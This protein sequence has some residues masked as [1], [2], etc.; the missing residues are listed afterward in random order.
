VVVKYTDGQTWGMK[1]SKF[2]SDGAYLN[3]KQ[4]EGTSWFRREKQA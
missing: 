4:T 2:I 1:Y 3:L